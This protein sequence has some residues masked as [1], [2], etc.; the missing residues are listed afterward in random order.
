MYPNFGRIGDLG[1]YGIWHSKLILQVLCQK[2]NVE[3]LIIIK[4]RISLRAVV[5]SAA[6]IFILAKPKR[7][8][9]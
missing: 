5:N 6:L 3:K 9:K 7:F 8:K 1:N 4:V 2:N